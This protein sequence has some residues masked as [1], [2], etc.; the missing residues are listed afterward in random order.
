MNDG[1]LDI[2]CYLCLRHFADGTTDAITTSETMLA[3][4]GTVNAENL[5]IVIYV[6]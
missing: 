1:V 4:F 6:S 2:F 3:S 5:F